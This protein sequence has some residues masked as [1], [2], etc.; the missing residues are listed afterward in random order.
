MKLNKRAEISTLMIILLVVGG[1]LTATFINK[2]EQPLFSTYAPIT[3]PSGSNLQSFVNNIYYPAT[4]TNIACSS[5]SLVNV[6][7]NGFPITQTSL[8]SL[9]SNNKIAFAISPT[10]TGL[11]AYA[12]TG[13]ASTGNINQCSTFGTIIY[14]LPGGLKIISK[15][16]AG[17]NYF[18]CRDYF[19]TINNRNQ[20]DKRGLGT[21]TGISTVRT[22]VDPA[23]ELSTVQPII[24]YSFV[25]ETGKIKHKACSSF[26]NQYGPEDPNLVCANDCS[27]P[28]SYTIS[29]QSQQGVKCVGVYAPSVQ[30]CGTDGKTMY[31][32]SSDGSTYTTQ[33]C[34]ACVVTGTGAARCDAC[35]SGQERCASLSGTNGDPQYCYNG[36]WA[37]KPGSACVGLSTCVVSPS[38]PPNT[39]SCT[40]GCISG[41][42]NCNGN[43]PTI[44]DVATQTFVNNGP[45]CTNTCSS[46]SCT[47]APG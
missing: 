11:S 13:S 14:T 43:Q 2:E 18:I 38:T 17:Y 25:C 37:D 4:T 26:P 12:T 23:N 1:V 3:S 35:V 16:Y 22:A 8:P 24:S 36:Q 9:N 32:T 27:G 29:G 34:G 31:T 21:T 19:D 15:V 47:S 7:T 41:Q 33:Q 46:G 44:C 30:T 40:T 42:L 45:T 10:D 28:T 20:H 6:R 5:T 39:A